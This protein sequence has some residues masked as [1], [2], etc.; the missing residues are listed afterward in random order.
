MSHF[1]AVLLKMDNHAQ[2]SYK[3]MLEVL[4]FASA[5]SKSTTQF[6]SNNNSNNHLFSIFPGSQLHNEHVLFHNAHR[7]ATM[8][9]ILYK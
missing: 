9:V 4:S 5:T 2:Y 1:M 7:K 6:Y 8:L 3:T